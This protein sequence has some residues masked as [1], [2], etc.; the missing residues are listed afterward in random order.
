MPFEEDPIT[1]KLQ[2]NF[3]NFL[4]T[5]VVLLVFLYF[6]WISFGTSRAEVLN[7]TVLIQILTVMIGSLGIVIGYYFASSKSSA[8]KD[9]KIS[10]LSDKATTL[11]LNSTPPPPTTVET[12]NTE[13][14]SGDV[15]AEN[16]NT[17][18]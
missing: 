5:L 17:S 6:F 7:N 8:A 18:K 15:T 16:V 12:I 14:I 1:H 3:T 2:F 9:T 4:A 10:E 11:A 13:N